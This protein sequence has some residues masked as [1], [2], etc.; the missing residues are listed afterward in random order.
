MK[1]PGMLGMPS[2]S[3]LL[4][5][6][7]IFPVFE[8]QNPSIDVSELRKICPATDF[9]AVA[10]GNAWSGALQDLIYF[11]GEGDKKT[12]EGDAGPPR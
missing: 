4:L 3:F 6:D 10:L 7:L 8:P 9:E 2:F 1:V 12:E 11:K 5:P